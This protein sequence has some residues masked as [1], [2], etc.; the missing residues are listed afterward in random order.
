MLNEFLIGVL[1]Q[2]I[3]VDQGLTRDNAEQVDQFL[4]SI[5]NVATDDISAGVGIKN[6]KIHVRV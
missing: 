1:E 3:I 2:K 5:A 6:G 4:G